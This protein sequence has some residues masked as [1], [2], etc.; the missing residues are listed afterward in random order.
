MEDAI[1]DS[2]GCKRC[3]RINESF[4]SISI[5]AVFSSSLS[6]LCLQADY[7]TYMALRRHI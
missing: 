3:K 6:V 4:S 2:K 5:T 7:Y 1:T